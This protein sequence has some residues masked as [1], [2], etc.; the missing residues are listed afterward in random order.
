MASNMAPYS[1]SPS[2]KHT[3]GQKMYSHYYQPPL[4]LNKERN[5]IEIIGY[6]ELIS[7]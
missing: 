1:I 4:S 2:V 6:E 5:A 3:Y 7:N